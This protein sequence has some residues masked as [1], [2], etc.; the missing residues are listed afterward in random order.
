MCLLIQLFRGYLTFLFIHVLIYILISYIYPT[1]QTHW[2]W[3]VTKVLVRS[4]ILK[5]NSTRQYF[6]CQTYSIYG[7]NFPFKHVLSCTKRLNS[8][9]VKI[10]FWNTDDMMQR[11]TCTFKAAS[12][13]SV[14]MISEASQILFSCNNQAASVSFESTWP[15]ARRGGTSSLALVGGAS[16]G[17]GFLESSEGD[18][19][20]SVPVKEVIVLFHHWCKQQKSW[21]WLCLCFFLHLQHLLG[22]SLCSHPHL[23]AVHLMPS[24]NKE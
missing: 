2:E 19:S 16:L 9:S 22:G 24:M 6:F 13:C 15:W 18:N 1:D 7:S 12:L 20:L 10:D 17:S 21:N 14:Y 11:Q 8:F 3:K 4:L 5:Q 23:T